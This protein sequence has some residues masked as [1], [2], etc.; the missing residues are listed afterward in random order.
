MQNP[1]RLVRNIESKFVAPLVD[2]IDLNITIKQKQLPSLF[3]DFAID[4]LGVNGS[5]YVVKSVDLNMVKASTAKAN[6]SEYESLLDRLID[7]SKLKGITGDPVTYL[8][9]D[10]PEK[11]KSELSDLYRFLKNEP[12]KYFQVISS[13]ALSEVTTEIIQKEARKFYQELL[14]TE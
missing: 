14:P 1:S 8:V 7:F 3:F 9:V 13:D 6:I 11:E 2:R 12:M 4:G 5:L 10:A